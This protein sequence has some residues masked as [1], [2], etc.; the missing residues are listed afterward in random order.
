MLRWAGIEKGKGRSQVFWE[1]V[2]CAFPTTHTGHTLYLFY[3]QSA[4]RGPIDLQDAV[5]R[6]D[7]IAVVRT[8]VHPVDPEDRQ[9]LRWDKSILRTHLTACTGKSHQGPLCHSS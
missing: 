4:D 3:T 9:E 1:P 8:D 7:G 5:P 2:L 6:V